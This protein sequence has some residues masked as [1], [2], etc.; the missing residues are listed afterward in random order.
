VGAWLTGVSAKPQPKK[1]ITSTDKPAYPTTPN[2]FA[3][4]LSQP[5]RF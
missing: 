1:K 4:F 3:N 2:F 5:K